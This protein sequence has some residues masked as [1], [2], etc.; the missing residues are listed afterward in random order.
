MCWRKRF[1]FV[2]QSVLQIL[3]TTDIHWCLLS[4]YQPQCLKV[5]FSQ[6]SV[7]QCVHGGGV[8]LR[9]RGCL[10]T[11][12]RVVSRGST[13]RGLHPG[14]VCLQGG[15]PTGGVC[16]QRGVCLQGG[17]LA[18]T[19]MYWYL[20]GGHCKSGW[21]ASYRNAFL[22]VNVSLFFDKIVKFVD[23]LVKSVSVSLDKGL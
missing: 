13:Y 7:S 20:R 9:G 23:N 16:L 15:L 5:M 21:Y 17:G 4:F 1:Y 12:R 6:A 2:R 22:F 14:E 11:G 8:C 18:N 19:P 3:Q 10:P